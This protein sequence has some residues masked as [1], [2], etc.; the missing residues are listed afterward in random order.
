[1]CHAGAF[2]FSGMATVRTFLGVFEASINPGTMLLFSQYYSRKE[3]PLRMGIWIGSAGLGYVIA[4]IG[5]CC[6]YRP[7]HTDL[8]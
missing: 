8:F 1:M 6:N 7:L 5:E 2:N 3:Q 4:G